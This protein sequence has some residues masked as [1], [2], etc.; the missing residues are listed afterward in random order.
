MPPTRLES[1]YSPLPTAAPAPEIGTVTPVAVRIGDKWDGYLPPVPRSMED[2]GFWELP[3]PGATDFWAEDREED[4]DDP[5]HSGRR[6]SGHR[7]P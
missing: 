1:T 4:G 3:Q 5:L 7:R 6:H 2:S